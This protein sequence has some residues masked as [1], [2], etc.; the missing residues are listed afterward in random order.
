[1][2]KMTRIVLLLL[3]ASLGSP[4]AAQSSAAPPKKHLLVIGEEKGY[5]HDAVSHA[6]A[7]I[8]SWDGKLPPDNGPST[9]IE[10]I[11][12]KKLNTTPKT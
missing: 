6:M 10:V 11:T 2:K 12:K 5:R 9:D 4:C 7:T 3:S 8:E 1:M